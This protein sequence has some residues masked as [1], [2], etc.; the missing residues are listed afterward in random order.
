METLVIASVMGGGGHG[1][2]AHRLVRN[3]AN[4]NFCRCTRRRPR[5]C[6]LTPDIG[7]TASAAADVLSYPGREA[8]F[9]AGAYRSRRFLAQTTRRHRPDGPRL[10]SEAELLHQDNSLHR[11]S[12]A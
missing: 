8:R 3:I 9:S 10:A 7:Q 5:A 12:L 11:G 6:L 4:R 2:G 1:S